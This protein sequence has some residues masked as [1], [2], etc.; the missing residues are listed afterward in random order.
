MKNEECLHIFPRIAFSQIKTS[1]FSVSSCSQKSFPR[2]N[3]CE[4]K[5]YRRACVQSCPLWNVYD[6]IYLFIVIYITSVNWSKDEEM[7]GSVGKCEEAL[8]NVLQTSQSGK[9]F[10]M[11]QNTRFLIFSAGVFIF[12][13]NSLLPYGV[14][15]DIFLL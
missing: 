9:Q 10:Q 15:L 2:K 14:I 1:Q 7:R 3:K 13:H 8:E 11:S 5:R 6:W 12:C 4:K